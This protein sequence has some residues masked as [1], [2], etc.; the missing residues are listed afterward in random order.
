MADKVMMSGLNFCCFCFVCTV[1]ACLWFSLW[2]YC[3]AV[4]MC[5]Y[6]RFVLCL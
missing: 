1:C 6:D 5:K 3:A 4:Y 2:S